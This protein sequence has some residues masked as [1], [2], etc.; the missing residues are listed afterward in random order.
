MHFLVVFC[1]LFSPHLFAQ[2]VL[3]AW[4][5]GQAPAVVELVA[6][7]NLPAKQIT[8][9]L[10]PGLPSADFELYLYQVPDRHQRLRFMRELNANKK[11]KF[12]EL[13]AEVLQQSYPLSPSHFN[14][15]NLVDSSDLPIQ[16]PCENYPIAI[17]DT[18][19]N[20]Q[21]PSL[22]TITFDFQKNYVSKQSTT[23]AEDD[24]GHGTHVA[25]LIAALPTVVAD[26]TGNKVATVAGI[27]SSAT[28]HNMKALP[29]DS[30]GSI[31]DVYAAFKDALDKGLAEFPIINASIQTGRSMTLQS[32]LTALSEQGH[33]VIA[34]AGNSRGLDD[35]S[36]SYP[37]A[38]S[39]SMGLVISVANV[40][41]NNQLA[42][43][44]KFDYQLVDFAAPGESLLSTWLNS[45]SGEALF[46]YSSG[47]SMSTPLVAATL[48]A[49]MQKYQSFDLPPAAF[50]AALLNS[51]MLHPELL[52]GK[53]R[54]PGVL[55]TG[56]ALEAEFDALFKPTWFNFEW[57]EGA[58]ALYLKGYQLDQVNKVA[59]KLDAINF[60]Q[61][62]SFSFNSQKQALLIDLPE[63][64]Q[65]GYLELSTSR[66]SL[67]KLDFTLMAS[68]PL[69]LT[70]VCEGEV[71]GISFEDYQVQVTRIDGGQGTRWM[72]TSDFVDDEEVLIVTGIDLSANWQF[73]F[74]GQPRLRLVAMQADKKDQGMQTLTKQDGFTNNP[75]AGSANWYLDKP[76]NWSVISEP[77]QQLV[78]KPQVEI[79]VKKSSSSR[80]YIATSVYGDANAPE[81]I[82]LR[83]FR[84]DFLMEFYLGQKFV[85]FYYTHSPSWVEWMQD[86][87]RLQSFIRWWLNLFVSIY[88]FFLLAFLR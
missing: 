60:S 7:N 18:G 40:Q 38:F 20:T 55:N 74:S 84:D 85:D 88:Q 73:Q 81:V 58:D 70:S 17:I 78:L 14:Q 46:E 76:E 63:G 48:A 64:W 82:A 12:V 1:L 36:P 19:I 79:Y 68:K 72:L 6:T 37:A 35:I 80:C 22:S 67:A 45:T 65:N 23:S 25:G 57:V 27:C 49:L 21:H 4:H 50:R 83:E 75:S 56:N 69:P 52:L 47:T 87:P 39:N 13:D 15:L 2:G 51:L 8:G 53:L 26:S 29:K 62:V 10:L 5:L 16:Y 24:D 9:E 42:K 54:Y 71:C 28:L 30:G 61:E 41:E 86:K 32:V 33:F 3:V 44:S 77:L 31:S 66:Q 43:N 11:V 34:A 59:F